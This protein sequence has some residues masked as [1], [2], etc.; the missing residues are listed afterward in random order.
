MVAAH[1]GSAVRYP[2]VIALRPSRGWMASVLAV[3][4]IAALALFHFPPMLAPPLYWYGVCAGVLLSSAWWAVRDE[5]RKRGM[6][7]TLEVDG[8][9]V[10]DGQGRRMPARIAP[11]A[12]V[13]AWAVWMCAVE[14]EQGAGRCRLMLLPTHV[15]GAQWRAL[16][17]WLRHRACRTVFSAGA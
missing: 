4:G 15:Q 5:R 6:R 10:V 9:L 14:L 8:T 16:C 1:G 2:V 17:L 11:G 7:L 3:H 12:V 13:S